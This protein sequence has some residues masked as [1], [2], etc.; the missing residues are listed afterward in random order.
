MTFTTNLFLIGLLPWFILFCYLLRNNK[1]SKLA[2]ILIANSIFYIWGG[3][4][5]LGFLC[6]FSVAV[7]LFCKVLTRKKNKIIMGTFITIT[8]IP[9]FLIKYLQ[10]IIS[11]IN[12]AFNINI[13]SPSLVIPVGISFFT[14]EA[15]SLICDTY[16]TKE[17]LKKM[18]FLEI[19]AYLSFFPTITSG[20]IIRFQKF[21]EGMNACIKIS[22]YNSAIERIVIGLCKK[23]LIADKIAVLSDYY[24]EGV[25]KGNSYSCIGLWIGSVAYTIQLYYDFSGYSDIAIGIGQLLGF[26]IGENFNRPYRA[27]S[28]SDFWKRWH[29]SLTKWFR[30]YV[31][32]PLGGNRCNISRHIFNMLVVWL[33]TGIWHGADWSFIVWG[34]GYFVL[35][36][37]EK[38]IPFMK[39]MSTSWIGHIYTLFFVNI[40]W[41]PFRASNLSIA[42]KYILGMFGLGSCSS[43]E[44]GTV[45]F[46]PYL[47]ISILLCFPIEK[48]LKKNE[49]KNW[50]G[51]TR[52]ICFLA[53][54]ILAICAVINASYTPYIY[55]NF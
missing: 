41:V 28:I 2:L 26:D 30:D 10:F 50:H 29:I 31:Y 8:T 16:K 54:A 5:I 11:N 39:K 15:I 22:N 53:L 47:L 34:M 51:I 42:M 18:S 4:G 21:R 38:Y 36:C 7:W 37:V 48:I 25:A 9:L 43:I 20:P 23:V 1:K 3:V 49:V 45:R 27:C 12:S 13:Q 6:L 17:C 19:Y 14:F 46:L 52:G 32:I 55:G 35:L 40:L 33:L 44:W 24:F